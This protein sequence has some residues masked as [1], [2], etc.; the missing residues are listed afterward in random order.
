MLS[1]VAQEQL[2]CER[3]KVGETQISCFQKISEQ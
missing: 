1:A 3:E 2:M